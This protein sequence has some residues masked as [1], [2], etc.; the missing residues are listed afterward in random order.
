MSS[1]TVTPK[2]SEK[3]QRQKDEKRDAILAAAR[4][5]FAEKGYEGSTIADIAKEAGVAAGTVYL[6]Y[7]SKTDLFAALSQQLYALINKALRLTDAPPDLE[8]G[9][10]ARISGVFGAAREHSDLIRLVFLNPDLRSEVAH[11]MRRADE[12]RMGPLVDLLKMGMVAGIVRNGDAS[13]LA[14]I[15]NGAV[16]MGLYQCFVQSDGS[17]IDGYQETVADMVVGALRPRN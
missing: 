2:P 17:Q 1:S 3:R 14:R 11:R 9:T 10:R 12:E 7:A 5:V 13:Q 8:A 15:I 4:S 16:I 6:Y